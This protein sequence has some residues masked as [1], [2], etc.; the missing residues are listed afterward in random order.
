MDGDVGCGDCGVW[1]C[2]LLRRGVAL[3]QVPSVEGRLFFQ[4]RG[5]EL[6]HD[7]F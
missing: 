3:R 5:W 6:G 7:N 1:G 4:G 2:G